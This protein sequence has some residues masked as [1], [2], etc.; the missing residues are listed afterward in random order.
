[1]VAEKSVSKAA[2]NLDLEASAALGWTT[3]DFAV[4]HSSKTPSRGCRVGRQRWG[5]V[6]PALGVGAE[7]CVSSISAGWRAGVHRCGQFGNA[8]E[9]A[10][11]T[12]KALHATSSSFAGITVKQRPDFRRSTYTDT[13]IAAIDRVRSVLGRSAPPAARG[14]SCAGASGFVA[15][16][17]LSGGHLRPRAEQTRGGADD[18]GRRQARRVPVRDARQPWNAAAPTVLSVGTRGSRESFQIGETSF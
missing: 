11:V 13:D 14:V 4:L 15:H 7:R 16:R 6:P 9:P 2:S 8:S 18:R 17:R 3:T 1:M 12:S 10:T 5:R